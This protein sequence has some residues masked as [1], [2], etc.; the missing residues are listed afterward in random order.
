[1]STQDRFASRCPTMVKPEY[2]FGVY[3]ENGYENDESFIITIESDAEL[4]QVSLNEIG[5]KILKHFVQNPKYDYIVT[6]TI[7]DEPFRCQGFIEFMGKCGLTD[8]L[9]TL[10]HSEVDKLFE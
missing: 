5:H 2:K 10:M 8:Q 3:D 7:D 1:M 6:L 9:R 4:S